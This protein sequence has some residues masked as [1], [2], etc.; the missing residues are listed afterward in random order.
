MP[1][2]RKVLPIFLAILILFTITGCDFLTSQYEKLTYKPEMKPLEELDPNFPITVLDTTIPF[3]PT[4]V[5]ALSPSLLEQLF[6]LGFG[7]LVLGVPDNISYEPAAGLVECGTV[8]QPNI[9]QIVHLRADIVIT[10]LPLDKNTIDVLN[11]NGIQVLVVPHAKTVD[12]IYENYKT[13]CCAM[14][15]NKGV[16]Y[17]EQYTQK[18]SEWFAGLQSVVSGGGKKSV[19]YLRLLNFQIATADSIEG[20]ILNELGFDN[21]GYR[22]LG[23]QYP[24]DK[25]EEDKDLFESINFI[26]YASTT[27]KPEDL[28]E[29][30]FYKDLPAI[31]DGNYAP[32]DP[33]PFERQG[34]KMFEQLGYLVYT[35]Y[36]DSNMPEWPFEPTL[37]NYKKPT[38]TA[39][40]TETDDSSSPTAK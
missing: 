9:E 5:V 21:I 24:E 22:Y 7:D 39:E 36:P 31:E 17:S 33:E 28:V 3:A 23:W 40:P 37:P 13:L 38:A 20:D 8:L 26:F 2:K 19:L 10:S 18:L 6:D 1:I 15:G 30:E 32:I 35:V 12:G 27:V 34:L 4:R 29:N 16:S 25:L 11:S 14:L